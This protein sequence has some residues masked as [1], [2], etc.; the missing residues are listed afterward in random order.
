[1]RNYQGQATEQQNAENSAGSGRGKPC[2]QKSGITVAGRLLSDEAA[3]NSRD[4]RHA[5]KSC[6]T[7]AMERVEFLVPISIGNLVTVEAKINYA[8]RTSMEIGVEVYAEDLAVGLRRHANSCLATMVA[9]DEKGRPV[10]IPG[11][12][13]ETPDEKA[14]YEEAALRRQKRRG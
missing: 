7:V 5:G 9:V 8:G 12:A 3:L 14:R 6:V 2:H 10:A 13:L 4:F 11:L 1:M